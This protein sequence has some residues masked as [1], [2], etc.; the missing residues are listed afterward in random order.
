MDNRN[1]GRK[2]MSNVVD[3]LERENVALQ[4]HIERLEKIITELQSQLR[5][6]ENKNSKL[7]NERNRYAKEIERLNNYLDCYNYVFGDVRPRIQEIKSEAYKEF[8]ERLKEYRY[9][10]SDWSHGE[11]PMVVEWDD[12]ENVIWELTEGNDDKV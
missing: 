8:A 10:S 11:H 12:V 4:K 7:R 6:E 9:T 3:A 2:T 1:E 5:K